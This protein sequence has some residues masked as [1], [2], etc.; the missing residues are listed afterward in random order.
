L[1]RDWKGLRNHESS[2]QGNFLAQQFV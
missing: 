2:K 1:K